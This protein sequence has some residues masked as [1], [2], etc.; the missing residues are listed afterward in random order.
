MHIH[1]SD[2]NFICQEKSHSKSHNGT[3]S[4]HEILGLIW[5]WFSFV[6]VDDCNSL[7]DYFGQNKTKCAINYE[8][9]VYSNDNR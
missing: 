7:V 8:N 5:R 2:L 3:A 9:Y 1:E 6:S 4:M